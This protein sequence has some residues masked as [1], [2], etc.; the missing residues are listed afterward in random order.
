MEGGISGITPINFCF[1]LVLMPFLSRDS[2][3]MLKYAH[4]HVVCVY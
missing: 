4:T 2:V 3:V 1:L